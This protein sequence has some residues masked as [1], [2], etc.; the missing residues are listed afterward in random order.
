M[1]LLSPLTSSPLTQAPPAPAALRPRS[2]GPCPDLDD[3]GFA[4]YPVGDQAQ[5]Q[6]LFSTLVTTE[7][8][9]RRNA[10]LL[11]PTTFGSRRR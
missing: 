6:E 7:P 5:L 3:L 8:M 4:A 2:A 9:W 11:A 10:G 1:S